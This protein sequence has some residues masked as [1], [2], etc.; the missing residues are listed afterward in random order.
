MQPTTQPASE[1]ATAVQLAGNRQP[2]S[3]D[4]SGAGQAYNPNQ[5]SELQCCLAGKLWLRLVPRQ[6][7]QSV[8]A[9]MLLIKTPTVQM[10]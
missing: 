2:S 10:C 5:T 6:E 4:G 3:G 8:P 9:M 7:Q 1:L